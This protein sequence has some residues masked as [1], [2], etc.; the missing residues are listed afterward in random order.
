MLL[1][2]ESYPSLYSTVIVR[3]PVSSRSLQSILVLLG[4]VVQTSTFKLREYKA[5]R[6]Q[7]G[8][9]SVEELTCLKQH[10]PSPFGYLIQVIRQMWCFKV[11]VVIRCWHDDDVSWKCVVELPF[12]APLSNVSSLLWFC[13]RNSTDSCSLLLD[14]FGAFLSRSIT[15]NV[16]STGT[17]G[18]LH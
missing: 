18:I 12:C 2:Q 11:G 5:I 15:L 9:S 7:I 1:A 14:C 4:S 6:I 13:C 16:K 17:R 8:F 3:M 10:I